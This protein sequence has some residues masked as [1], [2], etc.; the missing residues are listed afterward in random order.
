MAGREMS[1]ELVPLAA[2]LQE[3]YRREFRLPKAF[4]YHNEAGEMFCAVSKDVNPQFPGIHFEISIYKVNAGIKNR[5]EPEKI[6]FGQIN[7]FGD[8]A[9]VT[10]H[11][12][13]GNSI[14]AI[15][16][17]KGRQAF[18]IVIE[19]ALRLGARGITLNP[20]NKKLES[21]YLKKFGFRRRYVGGMCLIPSNATK[22]DNLR[23]KHSTPK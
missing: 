7:R 1:K 4:F 2:S 3:G 6:Y 17:N 13:K 19:E 15:N 22:R 11:N 8:V 10:L 18:R 9:A 16:S 23:I 12:S 5:S 20:R 21:Y 14:G